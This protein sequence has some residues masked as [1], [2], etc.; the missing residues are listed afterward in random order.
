LPFVNW[1]ADR[2]KSLLL[3]DSTSYSNIVGKDEYFAILRPLAVGRRLMFT[4]KE[5]LGLV[6]AEAKPGDS[7]CFIDSCNSPFVIRGAEDNTCVIV[8]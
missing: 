3:T 4:S 5:A 7:I 6:G 1:V 8:G 2:I